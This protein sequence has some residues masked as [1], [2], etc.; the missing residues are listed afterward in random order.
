MSKFTEAADAIRTVAQRLEGFRIA[1]DALESIGS[2][3]QA[4]KEAA[5]ARDAAQTERDA[6]LAELTKAKAELAKARDKAKD[7]VKDAEAKAV[8][9]AAVANQ[10]RE[11]LLAKAKE[12]ADKAAEDLVRPALAQKHAE[13]AKAQEA[14]AV[15]NDL[16][17]KAEALRA[18]VAMLTQQRDDLAQAI[19]AM[20]A[21]FG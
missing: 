2:V 17:A 9:I 12:D 18:E 6:V 3:D 5:K 7:L 10:G 15:V 8:E 16:D 1:A 21:K 19:D 13:L 4:A 14:A 20:K 11:V